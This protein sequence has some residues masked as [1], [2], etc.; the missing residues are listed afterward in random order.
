[1]AGL[2]TRVK[3]TFRGPY[4]LEF[5]VTFFVPPGIVDPTDS[6][7]QAIV[8]AINAVTHAVCFRIELTA[9]QPHVVTPTA[10]A[11]YVNEDKAE[12]IFRGEGGLA[13]TFK[14]P[15]LLPSILGTSKEKIDATAGLPLAF[16]TAVAD[17]AQGAGGEALAAPDFGM[18]RA[19]RKTLKK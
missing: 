3:C 9:S 4:D 6:R 7:V 15:G 18:R 12:F 19:A 8:A 14:V 11:V 17:N 16:V 2:S 10:S 5:S 13:H 1:M